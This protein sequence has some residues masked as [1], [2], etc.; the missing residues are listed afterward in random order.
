MP[1]LQRGFM[2]YGVICAAGFIFV[3]RRVPETKG[4]SLEQLEQQ[5]TAGE[6]AAVAGEHSLR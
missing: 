6:P 5:L 3:L 2:L 1:D 4:I